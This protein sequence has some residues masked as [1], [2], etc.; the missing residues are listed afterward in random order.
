MTFD[1]TLSTPIE[2]AFEPINLCNAKCFCCPYTYL[3]KDKE[4]R[5]KKMSDEQIKTLLEDF[6]DGI[7]KHNIDP[8]KTTVKPWRYSDPLVCPSLELVFDIC[9]RH[10]LRISLTTNAVSFGEKKCDLIE[11][12]IDSINRINVSIIGYNKQEIREWMDLDWDV[13]KARLLMVRDKYPAISEKM[14]IGVKHK[15]Q[16][17]E[18]KHYAPVVQEIQGLTLGKVKKKSNWL[19]NRLVYNKLDDDGLDFNISG[20]QFVQGCAMVRGKILRTLEVLVDGQAVLC[21]DDATGQTDFG[22]VFDI[23]IDGVWKNISQYHKLIY[24]AV[25]SDEKKNMMC[26]TCSRAKFEWDDSNTADIR[27]AN[28]QFIA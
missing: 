7:K 11:K 4:Y 17:P 13:T 19:E 26:N 16:D 6:A 5:G 9:Q 27:T 10:G 25:Y 21:C 14:N 22:N 2:L 20:K 3:E 18:R 15:T 23:G 1:L 24:D 8:S 28:Q 12:Y